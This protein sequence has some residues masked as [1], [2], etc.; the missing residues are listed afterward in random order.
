MFL[1][2]KK[3]I[4]LPGVGQENWHENFIVHLASIIRPKNYVELGLYQCELFNQIIPYADKLIG[5]DISPE[6]GKYMKKTEKT[7]FVCS[8]TVDYYKKIKSNSIVIDL[9]FIDANHSK[10]SVQEDF[11]NFFPFVADQGIILLHDGYPKNKDYTNSGYCGDGYRAIE[12]LSQKT[13]LYEMVTIPMH[14]GVTICR[15]RLKHLPWQ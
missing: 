3:K 4:L 7:K 11:E 15:K 2:N 10:K 6:A 1:N 14:P 12:E 8:S 9:L 13:D 5:V